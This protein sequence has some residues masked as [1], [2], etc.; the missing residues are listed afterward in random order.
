MNQV[1]GSSAQV[2]NDLPYIVGGEGGNL[3]RR[4]RKWCWPSDHITLRSASDKGPPSPIWL[5]EMD[6]EVERQR[7]RLALDIG[8]DTGCFGGKGGRRDKDNETR[9]ER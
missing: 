6:P 3:W 9:P 7:L 5:L 1:L 4:L 8:S 2:E